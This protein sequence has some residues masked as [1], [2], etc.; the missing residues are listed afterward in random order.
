LLSGVSSAIEFAICDLEV[1]R[2][3]YFDID[4]GALMAYS[5]RQ[6]QFLPMVCPI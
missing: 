5:A 2:G 1:A 6:Q 4:S 3:W